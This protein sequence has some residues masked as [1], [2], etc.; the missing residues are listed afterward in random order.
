MSGGAPFVS[1]AI[2]GFGLIGASLAAALRARDRG[3]RIVA[4]DRAAAL[5]DAATSANSDEQVNV[6]EP[7]AFAAALSACELTVLATPVNAILSQLPFVLEHA[8]LVT[9]C[10]STKRSIVERSRPLVNA[11]RFVAGHPMAGASAS[12]PRNADPRLFEGR[13]WLLCSDLGNTAAQQRISELV[14]FVGAEVVTV[15]SAEHDAAVAL[16]SHLPQLLASSLAVMGAGGAARLAAGPGFLSAT[17]VAGGNPVIWNDIFA[18]NGDQIAHASRRLAQTLEQVAT[19][20]ERGDVTSA[21]DLLRSAGEVRF[22]DPSG[23]GPRIAK[24]TRE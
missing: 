18:N 2:V 7:D 14:R 24:G 4:V 13:R 6:D 11:A 21:L 9:D 3:V 20:L 23:V 16:T 19:D 1:V 5:A 8:R 12:G 10:G 22:A 17:R 15:S